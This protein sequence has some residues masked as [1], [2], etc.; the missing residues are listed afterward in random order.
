MESNVRMT[1]RIQIVCGKFSI[2]SVRSAFEES[3][4][5]WLKKFKTKDK[6]LLQRKQALLNY[7]TAY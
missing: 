2:R 6:E 1:V 3:V 7:V 4:G 5:S